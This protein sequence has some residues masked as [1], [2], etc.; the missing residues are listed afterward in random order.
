MLLDSFITPINE[1]TIPNLI[2]K[3]FKTRYK[4][5]KFKDHLAYNP[6][7][8]LKQDLLQ[9][10][11]VAKK[12][13]VK[14]LE[15]K[16]LDAKQNDSNSDSFIFIP[17]E[18]VRGCPYAC[19]FCDWSSGLHHK[20]NVATLDWRE[21]IKF[22]SKLKY[23]VLMITDANVGILKDDVDVVKF[24]HDNFSNDYHY[25]ENPSN[26]KLHK[27]RVLE[28]E[29]YKAKNSKTP[30]GS[31]SKVS[32]QHIDK[33]VLDNINRPSITWEEN[34]ELIK[35]LKK[36]GQYIKAEVI[37]GLPGATL[38]KNIY[39]F[40]EFSLVNIDLVLLHPW[41]I[42]PNSPAYDINYQ[43][44][45]NLSKIRFIKFSNSSYSFG[46][47]IPLNGIDSTYKS[48]INKDVDLDLIDVNLIMDTNY[49]QDYFLSR[50]ISAL[51]NH[52]QLQRQ[53][54]SYDL[55]PFSYYLDK[56]YYFLK[57]MADQLV[58]KLNFF[59]EKYGFFIDVIEINNKLYSHSFV[60]EQYLYHSFS[61]EGIANIT[62]S[63]AI[64]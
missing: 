10:Y 18:R 60:I 14:W 55:A 11:E 23:V 21:E 36:A 45:H 12:N 16:G 29:L 26:A 50:N 48:I 8:D 35:T 64:E 31:I 6:Y 51:Y 27:D 1:Q 13:R 15:A 61:Q 22:L 44:K 47:E 20:V 28:L 63:F 5:F 59:N 41:I 52:Y 37:N 7:L 2:T 58:K 54:N 9:E 39:M 25:F 57:F 49:I 4:I 43:K 38:E 33:E 24:G 42:L 46:E 30:K 3:E 17:W 34:K 62:N 40:K 53:Q 56:H 32:L 19:T